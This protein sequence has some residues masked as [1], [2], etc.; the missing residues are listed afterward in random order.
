MGKLEYRRLSEAEIEAELNEVPGW[1]AGNGRLEREF[2]FDGYQKGL[3]FA[4]AVGFIADRLDHHPDIEIG[5]K[6]VR[7]S[8]STHAT[9]SLSPYDFEFARRVDALTD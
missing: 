7:V 8:V 9:G 6:K 3:V 1:T 2:A 5:Y 4:S